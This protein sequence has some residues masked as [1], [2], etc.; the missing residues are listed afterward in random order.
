[1]TKASF[2]ALRDKKAHGDNERKSA[3]QIIAIDLSKQQQ[4]TT[5]RTAKISNMLY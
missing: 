1:M 4:T 2:A 5:K 3:F